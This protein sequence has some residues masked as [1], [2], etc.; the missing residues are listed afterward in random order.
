MRN[1]PRPTDSYALDAVTGNVFAARWLAF[2]RGA[3]RT[4]RRVRGV[5]R[6]CE[7]EGRDARVVLRRRRR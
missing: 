2:A 6:A 7:P 5:N 4:R 1:A 3:A